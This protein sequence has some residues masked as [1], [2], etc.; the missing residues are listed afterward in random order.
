MRT[1]YLS[2]HR[3]MPDVEK[4]K[5]LGRRFP[6]YRGTWLPSFDK[7]YCGH[8]VAINWLGIRMRIGV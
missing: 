3:Y 8:S 1:K 5:A 2:V 4:D 6:E 7:N